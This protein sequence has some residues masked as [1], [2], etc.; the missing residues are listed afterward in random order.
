MQGH[1]KEDI[2]A[3]VNDDEVDCP[4]QLICTWIFICCSMT[5]LKEHSR[6]ICYL[7]GDRLPQVPYLCIQ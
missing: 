4:I 1:L 2:D 7:L 5:K 3:D 6:E